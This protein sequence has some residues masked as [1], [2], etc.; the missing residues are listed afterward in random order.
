MA[1]TPCNIYYFARWQDPWAGWAANNTWEGDHV[2]HGDSVGRGPWPKLAT[3]D[4]NGCSDCDDCEYS[5]CV[6]GYSGGAQECRN[7]RA[8]R[9]EGGKGACVYARPVGTAD[10]APVGTLPMEAEAWQDPG[11]PGCSQTPG[12]PGSACSARAAGLADEA[13]RQYRYPHNLS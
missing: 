3:L 5:G 13:Q 7:A 1:S 6:R 10:F 9:P 12:T 4:Q 11:Y 2:V 8:N